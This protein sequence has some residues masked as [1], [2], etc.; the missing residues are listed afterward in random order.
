MTQ[1]PATKH[2]LASPGKGFR[3][4][5]NEHEAAE[6]LGLSVAALRD[7]RFHRVGPEYVKYLNRSVRYSVAE[8]TRFAEQSKVQTAA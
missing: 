1:T 7:W 6:W 3:G 8:L 2:P 4:F 5:V